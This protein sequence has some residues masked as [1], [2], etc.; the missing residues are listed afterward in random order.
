MA[1]QALATFAALDPSHNSDV[2]VKVNADVFTTVA[3][4]HI[5]QGNY[6]LHQSQQVNTCVWVLAAVPGLATG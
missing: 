3:T 5:H 4:F 1:L 6:L 2:T